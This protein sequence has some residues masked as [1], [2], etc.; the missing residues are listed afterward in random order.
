MPRQTT[1]NED[2][3]K[4]ISDLEAL[5]VIMEKL[6]DEKI[7]AKP[8]AGIT[9]AKGL[10][11]E[12]KIRY[13][14][15]KSILKYLAVH[16]GTQGCFSFGICATCTSFDSTSPENEFFGTCGKTGEL[17]TEWHTCYEHSVTGG[18]YSL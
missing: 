16:F 6:L 14:E 2:K 18:G 8:K 4:T 11:N 5:M 13:S 7:A 1:I 12:R 15:A 10:P 3:G 17:C 9:L